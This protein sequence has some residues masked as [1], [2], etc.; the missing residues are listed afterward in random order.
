MIDFTLMAEDFEYMC[1]LGA[2]E[3]EEA[4][5]TAVERLVSGFIDDGGL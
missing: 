2:K 5:W 3:D 4:G 1:C